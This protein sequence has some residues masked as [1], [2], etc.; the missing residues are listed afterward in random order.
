MTPTDAW[1]LL[2]LAC[3]YGVLL[4]IVAFCVLVA[5]VNK[6]GCPPLLDGTPLG[7]ALD[8]RDRAHMLEAHDRDEERVCNAFALELEE[9]RNLPT[10]EP[11]R[12]W[13]A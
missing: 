5:W 3:V 2:E 4:F 1:H 9:I 12:R 11:W 13:S 7:S 8:D 6:F 10:V